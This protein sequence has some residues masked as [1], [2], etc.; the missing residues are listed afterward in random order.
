MWA[1]LALAYHKAGDDPGCL[2]VLRR[3]GPV[4]SRAGTFTSALCGATP[5]SP[6]R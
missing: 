5:A 4:G 1:E 6:P 3:I 2:M